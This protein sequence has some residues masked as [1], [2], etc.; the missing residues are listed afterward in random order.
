MSYGHSRT[1]SILIVPIVSAHAC[2]VPRC[3]RRTLSST[4]SCRRVS[5]ATTRRQRRQ[6]SHEQGQIEGASETG[7]AVDNQ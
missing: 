5:V 1:T 4:M 3:S 7:D 2:I 6:M